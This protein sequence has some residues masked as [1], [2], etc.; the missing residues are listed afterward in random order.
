MY[1]S[2][3]ILSSLTG[4]DSSSPDECLDSDDETDYRP[5]PKKAIAVRRK[6]T[7]LE[8]D[9]FKPP[10]SRRSASQSVASYDEGEGEGDEMDVEG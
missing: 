8:L 1:V 2:Y 3:S 9:T 7:N 5:K 6:S 10:G 4:T